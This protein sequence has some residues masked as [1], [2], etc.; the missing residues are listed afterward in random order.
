MTIP[1]SGFAATFIGI[2]VIVVMYLILQGQAAGQ[3]WGGQ[4]IIFIDE[5]GAVERRRQGVGGTRRRLR[6]HRA[7]DD[8]PPST[9]PWAP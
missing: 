7:L 6:G 1:S 3:K 2:D 4:C 8:R 9:A 5:I